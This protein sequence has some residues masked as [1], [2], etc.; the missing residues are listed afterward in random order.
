[1]SG[2]PE[3]VPIKQLETEFPKEWLLLEVTGEDEYGTVTERRLLFHSPSRDA[4]DDALLNTPRNLFVM[5]LFTGPLI[6]EGCG[7]AL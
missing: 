1:M 3:P 4:V 7:A 6:P 5:T 2:L